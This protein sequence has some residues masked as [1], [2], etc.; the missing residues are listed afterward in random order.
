MRPITKT[1]TVR[2]NAR[3]RRRPLRATIATV[4]T[5]LLVGMATVPAY[6]DSYPSWQDV[7]KAK[8]SASAARAKVAQIDQLINSLN[9]QVARTQAEAKQR[10][11]ELQIA[12][13]KYFDADRRAT[14]LASQAKA[15]QQKADAANTQAGRLAAQLYRTGG[16]D[17]TTRLLLS[18]GKNG[19]QSP[20]K[21]LSDLGSMTKLAE[22][23]NDIYTTALTAGNTAKSLTDQATAAKAERLRLRDAADAAFAA[24]TKAAAAAQ[25]QLHA[26]QGRIVILRA[27]ADVLNGKVK[28]VTTAYQKGVAA[29]AKA[30][31]ARNSG[32]GLPG[33]YVG[34]QGWAV[35]LA[36][37]ITDG[38]GARVAP[39]AGCSTWHEGADIGSYYGAVIHAAHDGVIEYTGWYGGYGNFILMRNGN[40]YE[41]AYGHIED[42]GILVGTG[43]HVVAGEA[44][45]RVG[46]TGHSTGPHLHF[47]VRTGGTPIDPVSFMARRGAPLG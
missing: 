41:T 20:D 27:Q 42:G 19:A 40:G 30:A 10:G 9:A 23:T 21:L 38:F 13:Q 4:L 34:S 3:G 24:A 32:A 45:A 39:C 46:S 26:A 6:A 25:E 31:A 16:S 1:R 14:Q 2:P 7:Q 35:P 22:S 18:G 47:E 8:K 36:G 12:Q 44:I 15:A 17:L 28:K 29:R 33:G 43:Q 5:L 11:E 37:P